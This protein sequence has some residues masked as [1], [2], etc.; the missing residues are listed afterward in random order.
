MGLPRQSMK[1]C[2]KKNG[3]ENV[4]SAILISYPNSFF[5]SSSGVEIGEIWNFSTNRFN[6]FGER[7]AGSVGPSTMFCMPRW[8]SVN[9]IHTAHTKIIPWKV[10]GHSH[11]IQMPRQVPQPL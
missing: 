5:K 11:H 6:T 4:L 8:N 9:K 3:G 7:K 1:N 10:E 2:Y